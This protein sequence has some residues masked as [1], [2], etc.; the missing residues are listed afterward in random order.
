MSLCRVCERLD[1]KDFV[2]WEKTLE[3]VPH[4]RS[5]E[6][7]QHSADTGCPLCKLIFNE[8]SRELAKEGPLGPAIWK[9]SPITL[10][11]VQ[12]V[13]DDEDSE[14]GGIFWIKAR[15]DRAGPL[16][17]AYFS[18][19]PDPD[20]VPVPEDIVIG[21]KIQPPQ[22]NFDLLRQ[23]IRHCEAN[24]TACT[25]SG[26][27]PTR[28]INVGQVGEDFVK[29]EETIPTQTDRYMTLSHCW[30]ATPHLVIRT[31]KATLPEHLQS[32]PLTALTN[33]FRDAVH[34]TRA[35]GIKYIWIDS[36]CIVQDDEQDWARESAKMGFIYANS[37]LT[38]AAAASADSTGGCFHYMSTPPP[39]PARIKCTTPSGLG[40]VFLCPRLGDFL[41][42]HK[43][44][45]H[46]RAWVKQERILSPR[47]IHYDRDQMLWECRESRACESG[48]P[49]SAFV[50]QKWIWDGRL[51]FEKG[52]QRPSRGAFWWDWYDL[53][54]SYTT[55]GLTKGEDKLPALSGLAQTL[56]AATGGSYVAGL[57]RDHLPFGLL[58]RKAG[59]WLRPAPT[60]RAP[61]W[62]WAA[63]DGRAMFYNV[64]DLEGD[65]VRVIPDVEGIEAVVTPSGVDPRGRLASGFLK[66]TGQLKAADERMDPTA[67]GYRKLPGVMESLNLTVDYLT[68]DGGIFAIA[69]FDEGYRPG[70]GPVYCLRIARME[71]KRSGESM[72]SL[73]LALLLEPT[74]REGEYRRIGIGEQREVGT[75]RH[76]G[77]ISSQ[78]DFFAGVPKTTITI[79]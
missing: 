23:W 44:P 77:P 36:L 47:T 79:V 70:R 16:A 26:P 50:T 75:G 39:Q 31:T 3:D 25:A 1:I 51:H 33:T 49:E 32:I 66:I 59:E 40:H 4:H 14:P 56:E 64:V 48:V 27:L 53:V 60:Y 78:P 35:V 18:L 58:W 20:G 65:A 22:Q 30:G 67:A 54:E 63:W 46:T 10:R 17:F 72:P 21:R 13:V 6:A 61:T 29:L 71:S 8:I 57:W 19:Y 76:D 41:T 7:L 42:L 43:S 69:F 2:D 34:V 5:L 24:H 45:L 74:G 11:G 15:C 55:H 38:V 68:K 62:S 12:Y 37:Y 73:F 9:T 52:E 28:V